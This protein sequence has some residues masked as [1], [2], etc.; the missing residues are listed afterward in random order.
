MQAIDPQ[1]S[2]GICYDMATL[3][4]MV[5]PL[6]APT[7]DTCDTPVTISPITTLLWFGQAMSLTQAQVLEAF[8]LASTIE[9]GRFDAL[10]VRAPRS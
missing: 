4:P 5:L 10:K 6:A 8:G 1:T 3:L 2:N 7:P 9:I